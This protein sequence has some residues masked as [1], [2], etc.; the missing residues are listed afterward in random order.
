[1]HTDLGGGGCSELKSSLGYGITAYFTEKGE[2]L[3]LLITLLQLYIIES[4]HY[5]Y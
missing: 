1:M 2:L 3:T 4:I 5:Y